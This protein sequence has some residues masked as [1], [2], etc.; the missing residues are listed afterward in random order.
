MAPLLGGHSFCDRCKPFS[1]G[2]FAAPRRGWLGRSLGL[3]AIVAESSGELVLQP[4]QPHLQHLELLQ[5]ASDLLA[6]GQIERLPGAFGGGIQIPLGQGRLRQ[7]TGPEK[8]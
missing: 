3:S 1:G 8:E 2:L 4:L 6:G 5:Q 7:G